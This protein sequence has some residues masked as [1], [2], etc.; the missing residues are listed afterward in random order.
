MRKVFTT[1]AVKNLKLS[2]KEKAKALL[3]IILSIA[4]IALIL[5][6]SDK[7]VELQ[8]YGYAGAFLISFLSA[9]TILIP[10]PGW[11]AVIVLS[12]VLNPYLLG[13]AAGAGSGLGEIIGYSIGSGAVGLIDK[14]DR[15]YAILKKYG[16]LAVFFLAF[17][18]NPLFDIAGLVAGA[19]KIPMWQ[20]LLAAITGRMARFVLLAHFGMWVLSWF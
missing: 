8:A 9:A 3:Q 4:I 6:L 13:I 17:V 15:N 2:D 12:G 19:L 11:A 20:F 10:T 14:K 7:I 1:G 18:P 16:S 5:S